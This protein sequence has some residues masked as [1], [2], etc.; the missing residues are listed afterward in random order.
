MRLW[1]KHARQVVRVVS[2]ADPC[3]EYLAGPAQENCTLA[4]LEEENGIGLSIIIDQEGFIADIGYDDVMELKYKNH[5]VEKI[6]DAS[7]RSVLPG[8]VD[9]HTH[10]VW[11]GDR[12]HE[13]SMKLAGASYMDI[14]EAGGGIHFTVNHTRK[15]SEDELYNLL[16][17]RLMRMLANGT[18]LVEGKSGYGLD[19]ENEIKMLRVLERAKRELPI[20]ISSTFCGAHAVP[21]NQTAEEATQNVLT[22][23]LPEVMRLQELGELHVDSIDVFCEKGVFD[24]DQ[25]RKILKA[26][27]Q[28][29]LRLNF[30]AD[31]LTPICGTEMG[32][33]LGAEAMSHLEEISQEGITAMAVKPS[34]AVILP[35]TA[36]LL[37]LN[38][39]P[40]RKMI[41]QGVPVAL[42][43]DFNP[44]AYCLSMP[45]V[46][47]L[48]CVLFGMTLPEVLVAATI[49]AAAALGRQ[50]TNGSLEVGKYG[51]L[52]ILNAPKWEHLIYQM[53]DIQ[54]IIGQVVKRGRIVDRTV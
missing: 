53:G 5:L 47:N 50:E 48:A 40:V 37:R 28:A 30:H 29:G 21:K 17:E 8:L 23:Q 35:T 38:P 27:R 4:I 13:F 46:M 15:A 49:N 44:N 1:V 12:V 25:S 9:A 20:D 14:Y 32:A 11:A 34:V 54:Q 41:N 43:S 6:I 19:T 39:P 51:D 24:I 10:P 42:G 2:D 45:L 31:E 33:A 36:Y 26:G 16:K 7:G 3:R 52:L 18:V 22:R